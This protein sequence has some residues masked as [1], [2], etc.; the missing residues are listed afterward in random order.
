MTE[1]A[2]LE[3]CTKTNIQNSEI[4]KSEVI[5]ATEFYIKGIN[6]ILSMSFIKITSI[7]MAH[8]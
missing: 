4:T 3:M 5:F 6:I 8:V 2:S 1:M 7:Q